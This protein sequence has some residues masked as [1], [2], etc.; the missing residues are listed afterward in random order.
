MIFLFSCEIQIYPG[1]KMGDYKYIYWSSKEIS[2]H[3]CGIVAPP[4]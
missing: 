4:C 2:C 1:E 3:M